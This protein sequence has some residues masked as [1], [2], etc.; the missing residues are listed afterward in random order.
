MMIN[1]LLIDYTVFN[2]NILYICQNGMGSTVT[3]LSMVYVCTFSFTVYG[4]YRWWFGDLNAF[5]SVSSWYVHDT[6]FLLFSKDVSALFNTH[7]LCIRVA[8][9]PKFTLVCISKVYQARTPFDNVWKQALD[10]FF[11]FCPVH[12]STFLLLVFLFVLLFFDCETLHDLH[13]LLCSLGRTN[14]IGLPNLSHRLPVE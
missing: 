10:T 13:A 11:F 9:S 5:C 8:L 4:L 1:S 14:M 3:T 7:L 2:I 6:M 12:S